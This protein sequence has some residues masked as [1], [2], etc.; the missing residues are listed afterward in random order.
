MR[1]VTL[2]ILSGTCGRYAK[3]EER[4]RSLFKQNRTQYAWPGVLM[5]TDHCR[6]VPPQRVGFLRRFG[7]KTGRDFAH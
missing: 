4:S 7:T 1:F 3:P 6:Y 2:L 5:S